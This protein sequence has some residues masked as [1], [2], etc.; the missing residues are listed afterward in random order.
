MLN[1]IVTPVAFEELLEVKKRYNEIS[2]RLGQAFFE[3]W[4]NI[5]DSIQRRPLQSQIKIKPY[6]NAFLKRFPYVVVF[7]VTT[8]EII[9]YRVVHTSRHQKQRKKRII[10]KKPEIKK[11]S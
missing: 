7:E 5:A 9:V 8:M 11:K 3:D 10:F 1:F 6:R 2:L 4:Q